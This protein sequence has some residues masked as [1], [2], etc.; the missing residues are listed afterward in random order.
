MIT[1][2]FSVIIPT[3]NR[4]TLLREC[5][6][7][8]ETQTFP[9]NE[10]EVI[11][12]DDGS[13]DNTREMLAGMVTP[14][15]LRSLHL[16]NGGP[17]FARNA[18]AGLAQGEYLAFTEDDV[19]VASDW[20]SR[21]K[22]GLHRH[23][24]DLLEGRTVYQDTGEDVRRFE[25]TQR[26]S[27]IPCNLFVRKDVFKRLGGYDREFYDKSLGLYFRE[28]A[29]F[30]FRVAEGGYRTGIVRDVV[31]RHPQQF[32]SLASCFRHLRRYVFD[33]LLY[34]KHP[35][36][37]R[38]LIEVKTIAGL[39]VHR[40]QHYL[41]LVYIFMPFLLIVGVIEMRPAISAA[42]FACIL[43]FSTL[44]RFKYQGLN[45]LK[46]HRLHETIGFMAAPI[47][48]MVAFLKGCVR[49]KSFGALW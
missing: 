16:E 2:L 25:P 11:V 9:L 24:L 13:T 30:G 21:A 5:L 27:F 20:L 10:F 46:L 28:D 38:Q 44:F 26:P 12:V 42:A 6:K 3:F 40:P 4:S 36:K 45:A 18:G 23:G 29:D 48:Y 47:V 19:I 49:H 1:P 8:L 7:S 43:G 33:P 41:S 31:V 15:R 22:E 34:R 35:V 39:T 32:G 37:F 17:S 14:F